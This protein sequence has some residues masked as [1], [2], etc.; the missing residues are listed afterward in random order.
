MVENKKENAFGM[1]PEWELKF[2]A[3]VIC[4]VDAQTP[5]GDDSKKALEAMIKRIGELVG[6]VDIDL[7][8]QAEYVKDEAQEL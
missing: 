8:I 4:S 5:I 7:F 6:I 1:S 3:D 2:L